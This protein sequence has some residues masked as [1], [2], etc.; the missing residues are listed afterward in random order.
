MTTASF[1][2]RGLFVVR[3]TATSPSNQAVATTAA[4]ELLNIGFIADPEQLQRLSV[5]ELKTTHSRCITA[6]RRRPYMD[7]HVSGFPG[8]GH[9]YV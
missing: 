5:E 1:L 8:A 2:R 6:D 3:P 4:I 9:E 7:P